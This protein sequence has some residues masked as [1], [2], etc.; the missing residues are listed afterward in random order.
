M[1]KLPEVNLLKKQSIT[2]TPSLFVISWALTVGRW[3]IIVTELIVILAFVWRL[4]L[5]YKSNSLKEEIDDQ[6]GLLSIQEPVEKQYREISNQLS[7]IEQAKSQQKPV[8]NIIQ[9]L[10]KSRPPSLALLSISWSKG[11]V[12]V[13]GYSQSENEISIFQNSMQLSDLFTK[14]LITQVELTDEQKKVQDANYL[15]KLTAKIK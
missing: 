7:I 15:F 12:I 6:I 4:S 2:N 8:M 1:K 3:L 5:D 10:T 9:E 11:D 14:V 13:D